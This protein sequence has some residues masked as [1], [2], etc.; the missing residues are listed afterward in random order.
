MESEVE[1]QTCQVCILSVF[2]TQVTKVRF[3]FLQLQ[4]CFAKPKALH[5]K[6]P[7]GVVLKFIMHNRNGN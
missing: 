3:G 5:T 2:I 6:A 4:F 1:N 7:Q